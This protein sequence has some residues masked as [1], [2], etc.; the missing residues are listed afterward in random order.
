MLQETKPSVPIDVDRHAEQN[1]EFPSITDGDTHTEEPLPPA[2]EGAARPVCD[3][4]ECQDGRSEDDQ[5]LQFAK[6]PSAPYLLHQYEAPMVQPVINH[7]MRTQNLKPN[8]IGI[9]TS[10]AYQFLRIFEHPEMIKKCNDIQHDIIKKYNVEDVTLCTNGFNSKNYFKSYPCVDK[11]EGNWCETYM[12]HGVDAITIVEHP[13]LSTF[14]MI[15]VIYIRPPGDTDANCILVANKK[16]LRDIIQIIDFDNN[17]W[18]KQNAQA[19]IIIVGANENHCLAINTQNSWDDL[20]LDDNKKEVL[21][22][23]IEFFLHNEDKF[24]QYNIP[25]KRSYFLEGPPGNGKSML[26]KVLAAQYPQLT[27]MAIDWDSAVMSH[28]GESLSERLL[29]LPEKAKKNGTP[30]VIVFEDLDRAFQHSDEKPVSLAPLLQILDGVIDISGLIFI[31]TA[32][33]PEKLDEALYQRKG[34]FDLHIKFAKPTD[35]QRIDFLNKLFRSV[36][37]SFEFTPE[38]LQ[39]IM[40]ITTNTS[41]AFLKGVYE[42][43]I[44]KCL[45]CTANTIEINEKDIISVVSDEMDYL[46]MLHKKA[47]GINFSETVIQ[48]CLKKYS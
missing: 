34:R 44:F 12:I 7:L 36:V 48:E 22:G 31:S 9:M 8:D 38:F 24:V 13:E 20:Y 42:R 11:S 5:K 46:V 29:S 32:N 17:I 21:K 14:Y 16:H 33:H 47:G 26:I 35:N 18:S 39:D 3:C 2:E 4:P 25:Y 41:F 19:S 6:A 30:A 23:D 40:K 45:N 10:H 27:F 28:E 43:T 15:H 1:Y 37:P